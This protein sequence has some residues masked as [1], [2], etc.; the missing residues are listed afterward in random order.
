MPSPTDSAIDGP[1]SSRFEQLSMNDTH[2]KREENN[3]NSLFL[4]LS[5]SPINHPEVDATP[6]SKNTKGATKITIKTTKI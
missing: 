1:E 4:S 6:I 3:G 2:K 5:T